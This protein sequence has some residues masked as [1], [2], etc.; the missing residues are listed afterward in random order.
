MDI[1][2]WQCINLPWTRI[3]QEIHQNGVW[4]GDRTARGGFKN[5]AVSQ[6]EIEQLYCSQ[7]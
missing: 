3:K 2:R 6:S 1:Y 5:R 4:L 7:E